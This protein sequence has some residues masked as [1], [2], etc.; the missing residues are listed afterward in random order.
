MKLIILSLICSA[1]IG[2]IVAAFLRF[3]KV[4]NKKYDEFEDER[5]R[6]VAG[7][8]EDKQRSKKNPQ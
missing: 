1:I 2:I 8:L 4:F 7:P 3:V 6:A 5:Y